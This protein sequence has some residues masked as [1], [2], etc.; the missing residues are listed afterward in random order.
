[1]NERYVW[2]GKR[3]ATM[4]VA[5]FQTETF[6]SFSESLDKFSNETNSNSSSACLCAYFV[7]TAESSLCKASCTLLFNRCN[8]NEK[9]VANNRTNGKKQPSIAITRTT[10]MFSVVSDSL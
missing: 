5:S 8:K 1:M 7:I 3:T 10:H 9:P 4:C 2:I 6:Y